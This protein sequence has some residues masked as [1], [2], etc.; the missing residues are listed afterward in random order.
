M[1]RFI[2]QYDVFVKNLTDAFPYQ[3]NLIAESLKIKAAWMPCPFHHIALFDIGRQASVK[4]ENWLRIAFLYF[5]NSASQL[6]S[7]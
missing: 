6:G 1:F 3:S 7:K 4:T 2:W 5:S